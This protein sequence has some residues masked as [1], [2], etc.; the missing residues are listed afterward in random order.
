MIISF[1]E[2]FPK[3]D[4]LENVGLINF[5]TKLY[6]AAGS[7]EMFKK[8]SKEIKSG[9]VREVVWW[10]VLQLNEG[11]WIS[12]WTKRK[13]L[14]KVLKE[15]EG[16]KVMLDLELPKDKSLLFKSLFNF[17]RNRKL[18]RN[19][20]KKNGDNV[21]CCEYFGEQKFLQRLGLSYDSGKNKIIKMVY[22][23]VHH[24]P[25][26]MVK[27]TIKSKMDA[28]GK[29]FIV[30]FGTIATGITGKETILKPEEL[31][32]DLRIARE[33]GVEEVIIFRLAGLNEEYIKVI[34]R[35]LAESP[36][37]QGPKH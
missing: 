19:F 32:R 6:I 3:E 29:R 4:G 12:P 10:P 22:R 36:S 5:P 26:A 20:V 35:F 9:H 28:Y 8:F 13:A 37:E 2:E 24:L 14:K 1:Y 7:K 11:Y 34:D 31:E 27:H 23:S 25:D 33:M 18:I 17:F 16:S 15:A 21:Y 30:S